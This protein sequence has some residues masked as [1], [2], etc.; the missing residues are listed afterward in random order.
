MLK[1]AAAALLASACLCGS[2]YAQTKDRTPPP[3][4]KKL[5]EII[6]KVEQRPDFRY[7]SDAEW[8]DGGYDVTYYTTDNAKVEMKFDPVTGETKSPQ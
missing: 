8:S 1:I 7:V 5:S 2:A 3:N 4:S 6:A